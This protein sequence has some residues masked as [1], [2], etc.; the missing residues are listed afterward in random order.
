MLYFDASKELMLERCLKRAETSGRE[1]DTAEILEKRVQT[2]FDQ[3]YPVI[4]HFEKFGKVT[5]IDAT[6]DVAT[7]S[8]MTKAAILPKTMF[9][10]G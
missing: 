6:G 1:D 2:F 5:R 4:Q 9:L 10:L 8:A 3:S 7:V